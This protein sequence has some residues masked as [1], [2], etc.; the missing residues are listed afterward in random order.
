MRT[1]T[2]LGLAYAV[3]GANRP[4]YLIPEGLRDVFERRSAK[5]PKRERSIR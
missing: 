4:Y 1:L 3:D 2:R 5:L